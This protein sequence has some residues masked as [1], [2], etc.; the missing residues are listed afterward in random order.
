ML[1]SQPAIGLNSQ[2]HRPNRFGR[3]IFLLT[4]LV[5]GVFFFF[6]PTLT[7]GF[8]KM[9]T[10]PGDTLFNNYILEHSF[11]SVF[12][13]TYSTDV[14]SPAFFYPQ[15]NALAYS[16]NLWGAAPVY[17]LARTIFLPDTAFQVW[18]IV[19]VIFNFLAF[20]L[21]SRQLKINYWFAG[22]MAFVF[23]FGLP[24]L[25]QLGHQQLLPQFFSVLALLFLIKFINQRKF[26]QLLL[27]EIFLY[28]QLL[29]GIYLG[30]FF[31]LAVTI[32]ILINFLY[33]RDKELIKSF[34][35]LSAIASYFVLLFLVFTTFQ[36]YYLAQQELGKWNYVGVQK[37]LPEAIAYLAIDESSLF[38]NFYPQFIKNAAAKL[39]L[40]HE[41]FLSAGWFI[42]LLFL[43]ALFSLL[44]IRKRHS[45][46][47]GWPPI[48]FTSL[49]TFVVLVLISLQFKLVDYSFWRQLYD[50]VPGAG[51]IRAVS[52]IVL[53][54]YLFLFLGIA[55]LASW[56]YERA[57]GKIIKGS[58]LIVGL[59][60][61]IEQINL[62]PV[63]FDK[64]EQRRL[65]TEIDI[66][67]K[68]ALAETQ[69]ET[70]YFRWLFDDEPFYRYQL[71]AMWT[72]INLRVPVIN[73][74][75]GKRPIE[76]K[77]VREALSDAEL[78]D[79]LHYKRPGDLNNVLV[80]E[81][82]VRKKQFLLFQYYN[83]NS[84]DANLDTS[85]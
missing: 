4:L 16:D 41:K 77:D 61:C 50:F 64:L 24:R 48:F 83:L 71:F 69:A 33:Y 15:I 84:L 74:Y 39:E 51:A 53:V 19:M 47:V 29:A 11:K 36:P 58:L 85:L 63:Y 8:K 30:W 67:I 10:D 25:A 60:A 79:W 44:V 49:A 6:Q 2:L 18:M 20:Y 80:I 34:F 32:F 27:F 72:G 55:S 81:A 56:V 43:V 9:Q 13:K 78:I 42:V 45:T 23:A 26:Y 62:Y 28:L 17:W 52:R 76:Y 12:D 22:I 65:Q 66:V 82:L 14:W 38:Y 40:S 35:S 75:S 3:F 31:V 21:L 54:A 70:F 1:D 68:Q 57:K 37:H 73:G 59:V 5:V 7:S 46:H